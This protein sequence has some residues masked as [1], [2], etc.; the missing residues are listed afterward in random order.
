[1]RIQLKKIVKFI[2]D[3]SISDV[4]LNRVWMHIKGTFGRASPCCSG[5]GVG[6]L[7][8]KPF[9]HGSGALI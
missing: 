5:I 8:A 9:F 3:I 7:R 4:Y 1:M 2:L 6:A